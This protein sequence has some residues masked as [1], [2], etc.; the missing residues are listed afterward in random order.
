M[1]VVVTLLMLLVPSEI[2]AKIVSFFFVSVLVQ[3]VES[4][5][6]TAMAVVVISSPAKS[7]CVLAVV[8]RGKPIAK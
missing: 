6:S 3:I 1:V 4:H 2:S 7:L 5:K 8:K